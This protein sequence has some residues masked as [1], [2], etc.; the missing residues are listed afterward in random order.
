MDNNGLNPNIAPPGEGI[1]DMHSILRLQDSCMGRGFFKTGNCGG[2]GDPCTDCSGVR[3]LDW[4]KH[5]S[6]QPA[7]FANWIFGGPGG[8]CPTTTGGTGPCGLS[9]HCEGH[10]TAQAVWDLYARDLP[11]PPFSLDN[12]TSLELST[13]LVYAGS[14]LVANWYQCFTATQSGDGCAGTNGYM[15][16]LAVDDDNGDL[17]DGTPHMTAIH[18][19]FNRHGVACNDIPP[20]NSGCTPLPAPVVTGV[21]GDQATTLTWS[22]V[23]GAT[24]YRVY[25]TEGVRGC[26]FGKVFLAEL[27]PSN[28][29]YQDVDLQNGFT[30]YYTVQAVGAGESCGGSMSSCTAVAPVA[31]PNVRP[32][33]T[34][35]V[36]ITSGDGDIFLDN[37]ETGR[38]SFTVENNG[39]TPLTNVRVVAVTSTTHPA[40]LPASTLPVPVAASL[41]PCA[42][43]GTVTVDFTPLGLQFDDTFRVQ[44]HVTSDELTP[45]TRSASFSVKNT[46]SNVQATATRTWSFD[47]DLEGWITAKGTFEREETAPG[48]GDF[49]V[50]S[51]SCLDEQCDVIRSPLVVLGNTSSLSLNQRYDTETPIPTPYDRANVGVY[52]EE[53][54][55]RTT[56]SPNGGDP[57]DL[58]AG[59][60]NGTCGTTLQPGWSADTEPGADC[61]AD[62]GFQPSSWTPAALNPASQ[63]TNRKV[64]LAVH[65]GTDAGANGW[66]FHFDDV[67][68]TNFGLQVADTAICTV[69]QPAQQRPTRA[70]FRKAS[71]TRRAR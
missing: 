30:Y 57:Y 20:V 60:A 34:P 19:A 1:A 23:P 64:R 15:Q 2:Y 58:A 27:P 68:L 43:S 14:Q 66:G 44:V 33:P 65:Y 70:P 28:L 4:A 10:L 55:V 9:T 50:A 29:S 61:T 42:T 32:I 26:D 52:E 71:A 53:T 16:F 59:A 63:F 13:R 49:Y 62:L 22:A 7:N 39:I 38:V 47:S 31:G 56:V 17:L 46:Q 69:A 8:G 40:T 36:Q 35:G 37:C 25:R 21:P 6:N 45:Q 3:D 18:A 41:A 54:G 48:S 67:T 5:A 51:S 12:N 24:A 11:A